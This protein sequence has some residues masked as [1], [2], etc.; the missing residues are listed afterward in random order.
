MINNT[1][2]AAD[3]SYTLFSDF[4]VQ[5]IALLDLRI[6]ND[7]R[8]DE[9]ILYFKKNKNIQLIPIDHGLSLPDSLAVCDVNLC[10]L[11]WKQVKNPICPEL[12]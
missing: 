11:F 8:N 12:K 10:W 4:E 2:C 3:I 5:K 7:D 1:K 9:N 6:L